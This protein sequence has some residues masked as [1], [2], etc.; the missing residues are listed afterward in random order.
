MA[1][2]AFH[3]AVKLDPQN[4]QAEI[5]EIQTLKALN[6]QRLTLELRDRL[7]LILAHYPNQVD[8]LAM[9]A[10]DARLN[11]DYT[12][13]IRYLEVLLPYVPAGSVEDGMIRKALAAAYVRSGTRSKSKH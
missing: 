9:L 13:E 3:Q 2:Q 6:N 1:V 4:V 10:I 8:V 5:N 11:H 7:Q 12:G